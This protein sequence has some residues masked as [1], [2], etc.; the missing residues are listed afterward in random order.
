MREA[1]D[2]LDFEL[3]LHRLMLSLSALEIL[4]SP[5]TAQDEALDIPRATLAALL[6]LPHREAER[7]YADWQQMR[8]A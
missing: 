6:D 7:L 1:I 5:V 2:T 4:V 3:R 8:A